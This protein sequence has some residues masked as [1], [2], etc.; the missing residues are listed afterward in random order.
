[1]KKSLF[2]LNTFIIL[3]L[4]S[5]F[6]TYAKFWGVKAVLTDMWE[7]KMASTNLRLQMIFTI[8]F[9]VSV[10]IAKG[11]QANDLSG[12]DDLVLRAAI[13][14]W[15]DDNDEISLPLIATLASEG[16]IA[17]RL[18]LARIQDTDWAPS[19]Y[20]NKLS[21]KESMDLYRPAGENL[22][23][24]SWLKTESLGGNQIASALLKG[25]A[26]EVN[27][28]A[29]RTLYEIGE[30]EA[31]Y[32]L[33]KQVATNGSKEEKEELTEFL[34]A[35]SELTPFLRALQTRVP[36]FT[37]GH[38]ALLQILSGDHTSQSEDVLLDPEQITSETA[39]FVEFGYENGF[40]SIDFDQTNVFYDVLANWINT[41]SAT[42][43]IAAVCSQYCKN[44]N[45]EA[46]AITAFGLVG[47]YYKAVRFDSPIEALIEQNRFLS[48]NRATGM[49]LRRIAFKT[50]VT[51]GLLVSDSDL[52]D[53]SECL[54]NAVGEVRAS[55]N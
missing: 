34:S 31:S 5:V 42:A 25:P 8:L 1:M 13:V 49:V 55:R 41:A 40:Q 20:V 53:E 50:N 39:V 19:N 24:P 3:N 23:R 52:R 4:V 27:I 45:I 29:I 9:C 12:S 37:P 30:P 22:F 6:F 44:E 18:L 15:L 38:A 43:P 11:A 7:E 33:I 35:T 46:C 17:A 47:G 2:Q 26:L 36:G 51:G 16:N 48:S 21:R 14:S 28:D 32:D 54:G 10:F